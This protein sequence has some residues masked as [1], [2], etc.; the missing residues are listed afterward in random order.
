MAKDN[1]FSNLT[2]KFFKEKYALPINKSLDLGNPKRFLIIRQHNQLGDLLATVPL[3]RAIKERYPGCYT[4]AVLSPVNYQ[5]LINNKYLDEVYIFDK[6]KLFVTPYYHE[7]KEFLKRPYDVVIVPA[8][9][10]ISFTSNLLGGMANAKIKIGP[11]SLNGSPNKSSYFFDR[12]VDL[13]WRQF[14]EMNVYERILDMVRPFGI[15]TQNFRAEIYFDKEDIE[16]A[17]NF[18]NSLDHEHK[19]FLIGLHVGAGKRQN[20]WSLTNFISL[21]EELHA[22]YRA[23]FYLTGSKPDMEEI[24]YMMKNS[25]LDFGLFINKKISEVAALISL[26]DLFVTND[27][28][29]MHVAG[30]TNTSQIS[31]FGATNPL[32]WAPFG[33]N[34]Y[35]LWKSILIDDI[36]VQDVLALAES[37]LNK[38]AE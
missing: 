17:E 31:L 11:K 24:V 6:K 26:S 34:K 1:F 19:G 28:G 10:S 36:S 16:A 37:I 29:I 18:A 27:T 32:I 3:F 9:V 13:D 35:F 23:R 4:A 15:T 14:P 38:N 2:Y 30:A 21:A 8:V 5:G 7:L 20:R 22:K 33:K 12:R 25:Q